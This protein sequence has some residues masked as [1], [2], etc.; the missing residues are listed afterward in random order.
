MTLNGVIY[1]VL[2]LLCIYLGQY[3]QSYRTIAGTNTQTHTRVTSQ[4][5]MAL[6]PVNGQQLPLFCIISANSIVFLER[7][8]LLKSG[9][10]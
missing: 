5:Q 10:C 2:S 3:R 6:T 9:Q 7:G 4:D 8:E 1:L